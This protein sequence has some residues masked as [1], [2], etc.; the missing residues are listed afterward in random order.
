MSLHY[1]TLLLIYIAK[2]NKQQIQIHGCMTHLP[3]TDKPINSNDEDFFLSA[4]NN[5][6]GTNRNCKL[7]SIDKFNTLEVFSSSS[8]FTMVW[9]PS[10]K[11]ESPN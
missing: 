9:N 7:L 1:V 10:N 5:T 6:W 11:L 8:V 4:W 3:N 2:W